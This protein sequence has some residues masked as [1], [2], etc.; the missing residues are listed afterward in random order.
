MGKQSLRDDEILAVVAHAFGARARVVGA[1]ELAG[2]TFNTVYRVSLSGREAG[3]VV[4]KVAPPPTTPLM[5]Y[6]HGLIRAEAEFYARLAALPDVPVP[7]VIAVDPHRRVIGREWLLMSHLD[8]VPWQELRSGIKAEDHARL[9]ADLARLIAQIHT[10]RGTRFGYLRQG[11]PATGVSWRSAFTSMLADVCQD[12]VRYRARLPYEVAELLSLVGD[13]AWLLDEVNAPALVHFDLWDGNVLLAERD[14]RLDIS[15]IIDGERTFWGDPLADLVS[16]A[17][18]DD[19]TRDTGFVGAYRTAVAAPP[20]LTAHEL[21]RIALYR[22]YLALIVLI[23]AVPRGYDPEARTSITER[24]T[25][26]LSATVARL[27]RAPGRRSVP[28]P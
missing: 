22:I 16:P 14:G 23:E 3:E 7:R 1:D 26:D 10:V 5:T 27:R 11:T 28:R 15:G 18:F 8:G 2:G 9:R 19:I 6:E 24:A 12:A 21:W 17:L 25:A 20:R 13:R 4:L